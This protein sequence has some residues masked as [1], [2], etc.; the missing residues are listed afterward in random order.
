MPD[1]SV[2][3]DLAEFYEVSIPEIIDGERKSEN[4]NKE[5]KETALKIS[6]YAE[7]INQKI[8]FR[9]FWLTILALIG[10]IAFVII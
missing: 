7:T 3:V 2:L 6:D 4:M 9:L 10:M 1:I 5:V 8:R